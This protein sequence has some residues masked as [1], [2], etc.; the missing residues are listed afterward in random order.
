MET[1]QVV[2]LETFSFLSRGK[3]RPVMFTP[4]SVGG[5]LYYLKGLGSF[6]ISGPAPSELKTTPRVKYR[7]L[8]CPIMIEDKLTKSNVSS[9]VSK[10]IEG[11]LNDGSIV[12][13]AY[14]M[15]EFVYEREAKRCTDLKRY[16]QD[17][18][19]MLTV[20]RDTSYTV[21]TDVRDTMNLELRADLGSVISESLRD[22][23]TSYA[24]TFRPLMRWPSYT[25]E[26]LSALVASMPDKPRQDAWGGSNGSKTA[27]SILGASSDIDDVPIF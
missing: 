21:G 13:E 10:Y 11:G 19:R 4:V 8:V 23:L 24:E 7:T 18:Y 3:T 25:A 16:R 12:I 26:E 22:R 17:A 1:K 14:E 20:V 5:T 9:L 2:K 27:D 15:P 6:E